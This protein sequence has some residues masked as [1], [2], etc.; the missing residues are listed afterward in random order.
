MS[1]TSAFNAVTKKHFDDIKNKLSGNKQV[2]PEVTGP[3][4][5]DF[6]DDDITIPD[7]DANSTF[8][9]TYG[10]E[11][12]SGIDLPTTKFKKTD[13]PKDMRE[14]IPAP[15]DN[16]VFNTEAL[17]GANLAVQYNKA[18]SISGPPGSGKTT[19]IREICAR[20]N[21]PYMRINGKD[22]VEL[23]SLMGQWTVED[24]KTVWQWGLLPKAVM[25]GYTV[26]LDEWTKLPP[27][28]MMGLQWLLEDEG[29]LLVEDAPGEFHDKLI[30]PHPQFRIVLCDNVKGLGDGIDKFAA[31]N[32][33][34]TATLNRF[35]I[36]LTMDYMK[37]EQEVEMLKKVHP[38]LTNKVA[39]QMVDTAN[40]IRTSYKEGNTS[41]SCSPRNLLAWAEWFLLFRDPN[42]G[43][44]YAYWN[45][46]A[47]D[48]EKSH[49]AQLYFKC[50]K[51]DLH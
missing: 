4:E 30:T 19:L 51:K 50:F 37:V 6:V 21:R 26:A 24:G 49:V 23:S 18:C 47:E 39:G 16:Y 36:N 2:E 35:S 40:L 11:A 12:P 34:D 46:L 27:G 31:T 7:S 48:S 25:E 28:I 45:A 44:K 29:K 20:T 38:K 1:N 8:Q 43:F 15:D 10:V 42:V 41:L 3:E 33:Q 22:G 14:H 13:W 9:A 5:P 17:E 32:V